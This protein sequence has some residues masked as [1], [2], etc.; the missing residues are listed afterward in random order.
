MILGEITPLASDMM[1]SSYVAF[2]GAFGWMI[3]TQIKTNN[4]FKDAI[5]EFRVTI[6][7]L[8]YQNQNQAQNCNKHRANTDENKKKIETLQL[9]ITR[10]KTQK[11]DQKNSK[12]VEIR[13]T[14]RLAKG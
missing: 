1:V 4:N 6:Q 12:K 2:L 8:N 11:D 5:N 9:Q 3:I 7:M 10:I 14:S 13:N